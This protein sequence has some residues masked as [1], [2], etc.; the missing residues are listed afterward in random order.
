MQRTR[1]T[2]EKA[3]EDMSKDELDIYA[4]DKFAVEL[5][6]RRRIE[7]LVEHVKTLVNNKGKVVEAAVKAERKPKIVRHLK[8]GV[9]WFW[10]P[11]YKGNPDL[12]VI[13][14]E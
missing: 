7:D 3:I 4:R 8:T 14:W 9:E 6:K 12:E 10:S 2:V 11:L 1:N 5:D 13:E